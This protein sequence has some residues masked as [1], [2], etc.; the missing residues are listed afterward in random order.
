MVEG[1]PCEIFPFLG[2][3]RLEEPL[4]R[5]QVTAV[6]HGHAHRVAAEGKTTAGVPVYNVGIPVMRANYPD[7]PPFRLIT[8]PV[9]PVQVTTTPVAMAEGRPVESRVEASA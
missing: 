5:Y 3:S 9:M 2:C 7:R 6:V 8:L 1:E 4:N